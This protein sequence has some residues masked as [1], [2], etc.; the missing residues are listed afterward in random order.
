[1]TPRAAALRRS[2][3][4]YWRDR[5]R[6]ARMDALHAS[7]VPPGGLAFDIGAHVGDRSA[8]FRRLGAQVV[9]VEPQ[10]GPL[11]ALRLIFARD[12]GVTL[13]GAAV[14]AAEGRAA[15][16]LNAAN[17]TV[18]TLSPAFIAAA[19]HD[20][21]WQGQRWDGQVSVPVT[22]LDALIAAHGRPDFAK[23]DVE[24]LEDAVLAGLSQPLPALSVEITTIRRGVGHACLDR[25]GAL[26]TYRF[27]LSMGEDHALRTGWLD[28][29]GMHAALAALPDEANSGDVF[30]RLV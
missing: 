3:D 24:G 6:T 29:D 13:V 10:P 22:T 8:S 28:R 18:A 17:P 5:G 11:R 21:N 4:I 15:L 9:A 2:F 12:P 25:L 26:G 19:R 27:A 30:A 16:H 1:M 7:I 14:G 20:P 23:I